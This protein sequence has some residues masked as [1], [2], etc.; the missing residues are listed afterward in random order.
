MRRDV[1]SA[2]AIVVA[3]AFTA[4]GGRDDAAPST[5]TEFGGVRAARAVESPPPAVYRGPKRRGWMSAAAK[6]GRVIY[7][8]ANSSVL[9]FPE[10]GRN[11][12]PLGEITDGISGAYGLCVDG[13]GNLYVANQSNN[14]VTKYLRGSTS[15]SVVYSQNLDRPLYPIVDAQGDLFVSNANNG[16]VVEYLAG[17]T[18]AH[19]VLQTLGREADGMDFDAQG[20][21]Y[22]AYRFYNGG[23]IEKF[24]PGSTQ[25]QVIGMTLNSPQGVQV[26]SAGT[27][28]AV[29][30][31]GTNRID[32]FPPGYTSPVLEVPVPQT[33]TELALTANEHKILVSTF[34]MGTIYV[35]PY[36]L[37][38]PN[39][40][41]NVLHEKLDVTESGP[42]Q[43]IALSNGKPY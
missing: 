27:I 9:I 7:V 12:E 10:R 18:D 36:P 11:P 13:N 5:A 42:V 32:V 33:P 37:L 23:S 3:L 14:T 35:S 41:P 17:S 31:D 4:C 30:T 15:A 40:S 8:A 26:S 19:E 16:T 39:G 1:V 20:N 38:N 21:L 2:G 29:E 22:V 24:A 43:G 6:I 34:S 28:L 25:G